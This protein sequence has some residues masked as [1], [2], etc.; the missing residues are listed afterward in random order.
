MPS[1]EAAAS[2]QAVYQAPP[3][4]YNGARRDRYAWSQTIGELDVRVFVG[5]DV[6]KGNQVQVIFSR[7]HLVVRAKTSDGGWTALVDGELPFDINR[8]NSIWTLVPREHVHVRVLL[9]SDSCLR[10]RLML[11]LSVDASVF[12]A[13]T[14]I[15]LA[16]MQERWWDRLFVNEPAI[17]THA[18]DCSRPMEELQPDAQATCERLLFDER[19]KQLGLPTSQQLVFNS[20]T[21]CLVYSYI[22]PILT[23]C[24][25]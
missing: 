5:R 13:L 24:F 20:C 12:S 7:H 16:K 17:D 18:I 15:Q 1:S 8:E 21:L 4:S 14:Q 22:G 11:D 19:Q 25:L 9:L 2:G 3:E 23:G 10:R 6:L